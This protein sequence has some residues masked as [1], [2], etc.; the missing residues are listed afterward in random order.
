MK[1]DE[2]PQDK[3]YLI[4]GRISD[5]NYAVDADGK[6]SSTQS[7]GW[8]PKN[9]AMDLAWSLVY[10]KAEEARKGILSGKL[11]PLAFY[12]ELNIMDVNILAAYTGLSRWKVRRHL[13]MKNFKKLHPDLLAQ[14]ATILN[15]SVEDLVN[16]DMIREMKLTHED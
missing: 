6:Y 2:V 8:K 16:I 15:I 9:D 14:Y 11:S 4:P 10:E 1:I 7:H 13:K 3:G 5:L 12:M